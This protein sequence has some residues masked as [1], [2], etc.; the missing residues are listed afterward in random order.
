MDGIQVKPPEDSNENFS[1]GV[2][3][4]TIDDNGVTT[5]LSDTDI[6][7]IAVTVASVADEANLSAN[8]VSGNEAGWT[9]LDIA[10]S[11]TDT[12]GSEA[13]SHL[14]IDTGNPDVVLSAGTYDADAGTW[15]VSQAQLADLKV[16]HTDD[17][18]SGTFD[19]SVTSHVLDSDADAGGDDT[20]SV[21]AD[22]T[23]T[24]NPIADEVTVADGSVAGAEDNWMTI[25]DGPVFT[26]TDTT[27][28]SEA[29][30]A[31]DLSGIPTGTEL[32]LA[33][34]TTIT[35]DGD[36]TAELPA[37]A[38]SDIGNNQFTID[39]LMVKAPADSNV[40]FEID[41]TAT[42]T[43]SNGGTSHVLADAG[44]G[45]I[46]VEVSSVAD[47]A[48]NT[49]NDV[50]GTEAGWATLDLASSVTDSDG[51]ESITHLVIDTGSSEIILSDGTY[52]ADS[53]TWTL[54]LDQLDGLQV[55]HT[56]DDYAG[57]FDLSVTSHVLDSDADAGGD[58]TTTTT[59]QFEVTI[60]PDADGVTITD[61]SGLGV[62]N[63]WIELNEPT[64]TLKDTD[65]S[66]ELH[67]VTIS[68]I[69]D[70]AELQLADG[71][72]LTITDGAATIPSSAIVATGDDNT[73]TIEGLEVKSPQ[74]DSTNFS[75]GISV[76]T[77]DAVTGTTT[78]YSEADLGSIDVVVSTEAEDPIIE[79][80]DVV[81]L[82]GQWVDLDLSATVSDTDS[83][84]I[85]KVV[86]STDDPDNVSLSIGVE[87]PAGTWTLDVADLA[88]LKVTHADDDYSGTFDLGI[89]AYVHDADV[90]SGGDSNTFDSAT[91]TVQV[92]PDADEVTVVDGSTSGAEDSWIAIDSA[93]TFTLTDLDGSETVSGIAFSG[94]PEGTELQF[95]DGSSV[96]VGA[97]GTAT[98]PASA[99]TETGNA[100]EYTITGMQVKAPED[101]NVN[102]DIDFTV[103]TSDSKNGVTSTNESAGSGSISVELSSVADDPTLTA[104]DVT[105]DEAGWTTLDI[106]TN[107]TDSDGSESI[108]AVVIDTGSPDIVLSAGTYDADAGTWS[109][110]TDQ[111]TELKVQHTDD[112]YSGSFDLAVTSHVLDTDSDSGG[113]DTTTESSS[114]T[115]TVDPI[116]DEVTVVDGSASGSEDAW[117][118][119]TDGP[120]FTLSDTD[121]SESVSAVSFSGMPEGTELRFADGSTVTVGA[122]G[123][124]EAPASAI[125]ATG[126]DSEFT[127]SGME[128]KAPADS[129][130]NFDIGFSVTTTDS[131]HGVSDSNTSAGSGTISVEVA[132]VADTPTLTANDASG[133]EAGWTALDIST[134]V[135]DSDGSESITAVVIDTGS[136]D[137]VLSAGTYDADAGTWSLTTDQLAELKVQH[138]DDDYSG[139]FDLSV[140][141]HV[142]DSDA[143]SG[144]DDTT[145]ATT[146]LTVTVDPIADEVTIVDGSVSGD[147]DSWMTVTDAPTFTITDTATPTAESIASVTLDGIPEGAELK[148]SDGTS[149]TVNGDGTAEIPSSAITA[150][151]EDNQFT[152]SGLMVKAPEDSNVDFELGFSVTSQDGDDLNSDAGSGT[153]SV[154]VTGVADTPVDNF[155]DLTFTEDVGE[156]VSYT[157]DGDD[158]SGTAYDLDLS[159]AISDSDGSESASYVISGVPDNMS[160]SAG[161]D[162]GDGSWSLSAAE[163]GSVELYAPEDWSGALDI[164]IQT[165]VTDYQEDGNGGYTTTV[166]DTLV[167]T[168]NLTITI[169]PDADALTVTAGGAGD[170]D[171]WIDVDMSYTLNDLDGSESVSTITLSDIPDGA[172][173]QL[174]D[175]TAITV[176]DGVATIPASA[177]VDNSDGTFDITDLQIQAPEHSNVDMDLSLNVT[178]VDDN[179][180][181]QDTVTSSH[182]VTVDVEGVADGVDNLGVAQST[183]EIEEDK[184][185]YL[186]DSNSG[187]GLSSDLIDTDGSEKIFY[188]IS[189]ESDDGN[190]SAW[191]QLKVGNKWKSQSQED[192]VW[193][194]E[195]ADVDAGLVRMGAGKNADEDFTVN[196]DAYSVDYDETDGG[197]DDTSTVASTS[198]SVDVDSNADKA[199]IWVKASG[200]ED[201]SITIQNSIQLY[202]ADGS[203]SLDGP[204]IIT[205]DPDQGS[206]SITKPGNEGLI[207]ETATAGVYEVDQAALTATKFGTDDNGDSYAYKWSIAGLTLDPA[208]NSADNVSL[209]FQ[210]KQV[211]ATDDGNDKAIEYTS[212]NYTVKVNA[213]VDGATLV[214]PDAEGLEDSAIALDP[215]IALGADQDG[216]ETV[217]GDVVITSTEPGAVGAEMVLDGVSIASSTTKS[218]SKE[219]VDGEL[220]TNVDYTTTWK[221]PANML[222]A[223]T[224]GDGDTTGWSFD[225]LTI[226]PPEDSDA[227]FDLQFALQIIDEDND[228][229]GDSISEIISESMHVQVDAVADAAKLDTLPSRGNEDTDLNV[230][231]DLNLTDTDGSETAYVTITGVPDGATFSAGTD[232]GNN[233]WRVDAEDLDGLTIQP[234]AQ[235]NDRIEMQVTATTVES[236]P[237]SGSDHAGDGGEVEV[238]T[239]TTDPVD[240]NIRVLG[241]ADEAEM[242]GLTASG[243]EDAPLAGAPDGAIQ[244]DLS[245]ITLGEDN[246]DNSEQLSVVI[247]NIP[248]GVK[249][250]A[251]N[252]DQDALTYLGNGRWGVDVENHLESVH[253]IPVGDFGGEFNLDITAIVT[254]RSFKVDD[255]GQLVKEDGEVVTMTGGDQSIRIEQLTVT[256]EPDADQANIHIAAKGYEDA[257]D[258]IT[259]TINPSTTDSDGS[260]SV[261]G[262]TVFGLPDDVFLYQDGELQIA[263]G[264]GNYHFDPDNLADLNLV[265]PLH[266]NEDFTVQVTAETTDSNGDTAT[267]TESHLVDVV[268]VADGVENLAAGQGV[269]GSTIT[270]E[271][272]CFSKSGN[273]DGDCDITI[274]YI[275]S[276]GDTQQASGS[277]TTN[278]PF[279]NG[280]GGWESIEVT[281]TDADG[282][283]VDF[284]DLQPTNILFEPTTNEGVYLKSVEIA[285]HD[286]DPAADGEMGQGVN[287]HQ[288]QVYGGTYVGMPGNGKSSLGLSFEDDDGVNIFTDSP[289]LSS[290]ITTDGVHQIPIEIQSDMIDVDGSESRY[291]MVENVPEGAF[292]AA[293]TDAAGNIEHTAINAGDGMWIV[294]ESDLADLHLV[295]Q[296]G[297]VDEATFTI[298]VRAV[299]VENDGD[300]RV[301]S[302]V[303]IDFTV[304]TDLDQSHNPGPGNGHINSDGGD[305]GVEV[306][307]VDIVSGGQG[308]EDSAIN[309]GIQSTQLDN[310]GS[311]V[312]TFVID[313]N[314]LP[315]GANLSTGIFNP[316]N[317]SWVFTS[318]EIGDLNITPPENFSGEMNV[319]ME[320]FTVEV[321]GDE[322]VQEH[323]VT[324]DVDAVT[325]G[326]NLSI[327]NAFGD[328][329]TAISL[330]V[331]V[332]LPDDDGSESL[333]GGVII[334]G[335]PVGA[336]L[337]IDG[338]AITSSIDGNGEAYWEIPQAAL[339]S[340]GDQSWNIPGLT[341]TPPTD[342]NENFDLTI[343][344]TGG[345]GGT[346]DAA[347]VTVS[348]TL[349]VDVEADADEIILTVQDQATTGVEDMAIELHGLS[350]TLDG[351]GSEVMNV[352]VTGYPDGTVFSHGFS[353]G[354]GTWSVDPNDLGTLQLVPPQ[355]FSGDMS[356]QLNA[357]SL[358]RDPESGEIHIKQ[359]SSAEFSVSFDADADGFSAT[360]NDAEGI[361]NSPIALNLSAASMDQYEGASEGMLITL[362]GF[363]AGSQLSTGTS[364]DG[365]ETWS[366]T[367]DQLNGLTFTPPTDYHGNLKITMNLESDQN[368]IEVVSKSFDFNISVDDRPTVT[369]AQE[370]TLEAV[371]DGVVDV[372]SQITLTDGDSTIMTGATVAITQGEEAGDAFSLEGY[373][374]SSFTIDGVET[375]FIDGTDIEISGGG[376]AGDGELMLSGSDSITNYQAVLSSIKLN[377]DEGGTRDIE[378]TVT[379]DKG[380]VSEVGSFQ[381]EITEGTDGDDTITG[382]AG[383]ETFIMTDGSDSIAAGAGDDLFIFGMNEGSDF[384][385]GGAG[386]TDII[387]M[388]GMTDDPTINLD[389]V[390]NWTIETDSS[391]SIESNVDMDGN[392]FDQL[393]FDDGDAAGTIT[394]EDGSE[395]QFDGIDHIAW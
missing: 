67:S 307:G 264:D 23:V 92:N 250:W 297:L 301:S 303:T 299:T 195:A 281:L 202:D 156:S 88:D 148:L 287:D 130:E 14:I 208:E 49:A 9:N 246:F 168:D 215:T 13:I 234:P 342:S 74:D 30:T 104:N 261:T 135:T 85:T 360:V 54:S 391:Y 80:N 291:Y 376:I 325:D 265:T 338:Q 142:L 222:T 386:Y 165:T 120:T 191:L 184:S 200:T 276:N 162:N 45:A 37:S 368:N 20:S 253:V 178:V 138:T 366:V 33:D 134:S 34:G 199:T 209:N 193:T 239:H 50:S 147:E 223:E 55:K 387:R 78:D 141:S 283:T 352:V 192:G 91:F 212:K 62:E 351:T 259:L 71:T 220:V 47:Q 370:S 8:D 289:G 160:L 235:S 124:A 311:E 346:G 357:F 316:L 106:S 270:L 293:G 167:L 318:D 233:S 155:D 231:I 251:S 371:G 87:N 109:L 228:S 244:L 131:D 278:T 77:V 266:S 187:P 94:M 75:L 362:E 328:E 255:E 347:D 118:S 395:L 298:D 174:S 345:E 274:E 314:D 206:L 97:D 330:N 171:Q 101:S 317:N 39:G 319:F 258:G 390:D 343:H 25:T 393:T 372:G 127:L 294:S 5:D 63:S 114:F 107:V 344:A 116:A 326:P 83:E 188:K 139:S 242:E 312:T 183:V 153:I 284:T 267:R 354:D 364:D 243:V 128:V 115:V 19:L 373:T 217:Y 369:F 331:S 96:T 119:I 214:T 136:P 121:G 89:T 383:D 349:T 268:G 164:A 348:A 98:A 140:T 367:G 292:L 361:E 122:N 322:M 252:E 166:D 203:E 152:I 224:N 125:T 236:N 336:A 216:S 248:D 280:K 384:I 333:S 65:G 180:I 161:T 321:N 133:D 300:V 123:T 196:I 198:F 394:L 225:N 285:G 11:V 159:S 157:V 1:L 42:T 282:N 3:V 190:D 263:D 257:A 27:D 72:S 103:T 339:A 221:V 340:T 64:F 332:A 176:T 56:D 26:L 389:A 44:S 380:G 175:G 275:D 241:V 296:P 288:D 305:A 38:I 146:S 99:I 22:F 213:D 110:T 154:E 189:V 81:G 150:T 329:D 21:S 381:A 218:V 112:N 52:D 4:V 378:V 6:G 15:S 144:G 310:D 79:A 295:P 93:P 18:F 102:F 35:V 95:A 210:T 226:T 279:D 353:N 173:L 197:I 117:I 304:D 24:V 100:H 58:D 16:Q 59:S 41:V 237:S 82:E 57:S 327:S 260:E 40:N 229:G 185:F 249:L 273:K 28:G 143:D 286:F 60:H 145:T 302:A 375:T 129:N 111:L 374:T 355:D 43:D 36:G 341:I 69:P 365:G 113:N 186:H 382:T 323:T 194:V 306:D 230:K 256:V 262:V 132:S 205:M 309:M 277:F 245:G 170:E 46:A 126:N 271:V 182:T 363:P 68:N 181:T 315:I 172:S 108:T 308:N 66:E 238:L 392:L 70:G 204:V 149:I 177:I 137:I 313:D 105:G 335:V 158:S 151:G 320:A 2:S 247:S 90:D 272:A 73:F 337:A 169:D 324:V 10:T 254:E 269:D 388:D 48:A 12:D 359:T 32:K 201:Q 356:L 61:G 17:D 385:S 7:A 219:M 290:S 53:G 358:D 350:A 232:L 84:T 86:I 334:T 51:S 31:I 29:V 207:T 211:E 227:D 163:L 240:L 179:G 377:L 76:V 379:D